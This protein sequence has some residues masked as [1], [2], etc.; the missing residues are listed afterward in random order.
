MVVNI[1]PVPSDRIGRETLTIV[2]DT[3]NNTTGEA[4]IAINGHVT[5]FYAVLTD[6]DGADTY[7]ITFEDEDNIDYYSESGIADN[8]TRVYN[9]RNHGGG[10]NN[11]LS[12]PV[13]GKLTCKIVV[14]GNQTAAST[15]TIVL[16]Y[17]TK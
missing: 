13:A 12:F 2:L 4:S 8:A 10:T 11:D 5:W 15:Q 1:R 3:T 17:E 14:D 7:T 6:T 16:L 9:L